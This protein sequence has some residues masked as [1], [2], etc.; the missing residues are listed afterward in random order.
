MLSIKYKGTGEVIPYINNSRTHSE[1]Q[2]QQ[3]AA[4]I[5]EFGF[6]NPILIDEQGG[7]IAGH[8]RLQAAQL[9][10]LNEVPTIT[11]EGL[12]DAQK[13][14]YVIADNKLALNAGWDETLLQVELDSLSESGFDIS[15]LGFDKEEM[16]EILGENA[17]DGLGDESYTK[18]VD[19]PTY[20]PKG[21]KPEVTELYND[22]RTFELVANI[23]DSNLPQAEKD[24]LMLAAGR[25]TVLN[26]ESIA[27]YY[28]H[29]SKECQELMEDSALVIID[30]EKALELGYVTLS[31]KI[32]EQYLKDYPDES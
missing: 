29:S 5:K 24:F 23:K 13:K 25:H 1:K 30:F 12:T 6:T 22:S 15:L 32:S 20:E 3:V 7:I 19:I 27:N 26:F 9:L 10:N 14:A 28:A 8:G 2:V 18:K 17:L 11:L 31:E 16:L 21:D 4:S